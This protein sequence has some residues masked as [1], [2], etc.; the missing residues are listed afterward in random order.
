MSSAAAEQ[1]RPESQGRETHKDSV[2]VPAQ[3]IQKSR[4]DS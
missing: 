3:W 4:K 1:E 2:V